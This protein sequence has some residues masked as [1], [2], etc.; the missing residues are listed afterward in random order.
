MT[1]R[2]VKNKGWPAGVNNIAPDYDL[3][4]D[5][6]GDTIHLRSAVNV[7]FTDSGKVRSRKGKTR[8]YSG[9]V[10]SLWS[11]G[12]VALFVEGGALKKLNPDNTATALQVGIGD[13]RMQ[14]VAAGDN[15]YFSNGSTAGIYTKGLVREWGVEAPTAAPQLTQINGVLPAAR[16][17]VVCTFLNVY[18]E[19]SGCMAGTAIDVTTGGISVTIPQATSIEVM[20]VNVYMT[21]PNGDEYYLAKTVS[22]AASTQITEEPVYGKI[23]KTQFCARMIP[24]ELIEIYKGIMYAAVGNI[25]WHSE[26]YNYGLYMPA[27][28]YMVFNGEITVMA[29]TANG[30]YVVNDVT[31]YLAGTGPVDFTP[32]EVAPYGA[33]KYSAVHLKDGQ[34]MIWRSHRGI[35]Q[36]DD[37]GKVTNL[38]EDRVFPAQAEQGTTIIREQDSLKQ[39]VSVGIN[40]PYPAALVASDYWEAEVIRQRS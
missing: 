18:G 22:L 29:S 15:V 23:L 13:A 16:Y 12:K 21:P 35:T 11:D 33:A 2:V 25:I 9:S 32:T 27:K 10:H 36:G 24:G 17:Q 37:G 38:Q 20:K 3:P 4:T 5:K 34:S 28:N 26:P 30:M 31:W 1:E 14:Y 8:I 6:F 19:E 40:A 7:D 39:I